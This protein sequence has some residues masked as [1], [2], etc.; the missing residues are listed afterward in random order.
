MA[1]A[2]ADLNRGLNNL[3]WH[4]DLEVIRRA[5]EDRYPSLAPVNVLLTVLLEQATGAKDFALWRRVLMWDDENLWHFIL[6]H[7]N[8]SGGCA[9]EP[10]QLVKWD[11]SGKAH[12]GIVIQVEDGA[13]TQ[14][15]EA[16]KMLM[17]V[18]EKVAPDQIRFAWT[19]SLKPRTLE[20]GFY[21]E[22]SA[23]LAV[24]QVDNRVLIE[25]D[26][27]T[28][29]SA[30]A[31]SSVKERIIRANGDH[32]RLRLALDTLG[33]GVEDFNGKA[34]AGTWVFLDRDELGFVVVASPDNSPLI[35]MQQGNTTPVFNEIDP[36]RIKQI[37]HPSTES[38]HYTDAKS[39]VFADLN[40][41]IGA[42]R[43]WGEE[44]AQVLN[45]LFLDEDVRRLMSEPAARLAR[46][47]P[48][49]PEEWAGYAASSGSL[50]E[51]HPSPGDLL[52]LDD[53]T[54]AIGL[55][56]D[57]MLAQTKSYKLGIRAIA[58][59]AKIWQPA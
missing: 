56:A 17:I 58:H 24:V 9:A 7:G 11:T 14:L 47:G 15:L 10:G 52:I 32:E 46:R 23:F 54:Q 29:L 48:T 26:M 16:N 59:T 55:D 25:S 30:K 42:L 4:G 12:T 37:W 45:P 34:P 41:A 2:F 38:K 40:A 57:E 49:D 20:S 21:G 27:I 1:D 35:I 8:P 28:E 39:A 44:K 31:P 5:G 53:G 50:R 43:M 19:P 33:A 3:L 18:E 36:A 6:A 13:V 22:A 51:G